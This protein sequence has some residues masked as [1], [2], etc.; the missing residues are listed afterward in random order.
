[1]VLPENTVIDSPFPIRLK[2][3]RLMRGYSLRE[4]SHKMGDA[5]SHVALTKYEDGAMKPSGQVLAALCSALG[6]SP[7]ALFR[8]TSIIVSKVSFR[9]QKAFGEKD[10]TALVERIRAYLEN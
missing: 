4:L 1:M 5:V 3:A 2:Q 9:K 6:V 8:P 7:D 10:T